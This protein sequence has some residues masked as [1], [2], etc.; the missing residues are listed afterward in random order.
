V[1][2]HAGLAGWLAGWQGERNRQRDDDESSY[3]S[4]PSQDGAAEGDAPAETTWALLKDAAAN[5][6]FRL[7]LAMQL[8]VYSNTVFQV[9]CASDGL[10]D[11]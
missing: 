7:W 10:R 1:F 4:Q 5:H 6:N 9:G 8:C 2:R 3:P 11:G